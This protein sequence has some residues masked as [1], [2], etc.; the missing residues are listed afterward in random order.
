MQADCARIIQSFKKMILGSD[1]YTCSRN[2]PQRIEFISSCSSTILL[3]LS[4]IFHKDYTSDTIS[5]HF[6]EILPPLN[7]PITE[8][9]TIPL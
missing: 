5:I 9:G 7:G 8:K 6:F 1:P 4:V 2:A 3:R